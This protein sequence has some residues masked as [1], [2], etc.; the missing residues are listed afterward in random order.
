MHPG[1]PGGEGGLS[2]TGNTARRV[3]H[4]MQTDHVGDCVCYFGCEDQEHIQRSGID[5]LGW[6]D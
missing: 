4:R 2:C 1:T 6:G 3:S 5:S